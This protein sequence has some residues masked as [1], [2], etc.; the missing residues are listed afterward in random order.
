MAAKFRGRAK[1]DDARLIWHNE[2]SGVSIGAGGTCHSDWPSAH[3][4]R[5]C[6]WCARDER[7][8]ARVFEEFEAHN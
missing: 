3:A 8:I 1:N 4:Q 2:R 5:A 6:S 7:L